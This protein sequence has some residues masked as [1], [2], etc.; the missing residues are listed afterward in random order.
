[1]HVCLD[2]PR[3]GLSFHMAWVCQG[4]LLCDACL[5]CVTPCGHSLGREFRPA[6]VLVA[7]CCTFVLA[8]HHLA[9]VSPLHGFVRARCHVV[10]CLPGVPPDVYL[11]QQKIA[12]TELLTNYGPGT[13]CSWSRDFGCACLLHIPSAPVLWLCCPSLRSSGSAD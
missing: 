4:A 7:D 12:L 8:L 11:A 9:V 3:L 6:Y 13:G 1:M 5:V 2:P 10:L